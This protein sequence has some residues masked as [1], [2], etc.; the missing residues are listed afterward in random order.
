MKLFKSIRLEKHV[1]I[2]LATLLMSACVFVGMSY[3]SSSNDA[4]ASASSSSLS[5][6]ANSGND[7][8]VLVTGLP[9][10][11]Q[12]VEKTSPAVVNIRTTQKIAQ[13]QLD[14]FGED[15]PTQELLRRF[16]GAPNPMQPNPK[17]KRVQPKQQNRKCRAVWVPDLSSLPMALF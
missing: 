9:D 1:S 3:L 17:N 14:P 15:D 11:T 12:L 8:P 10:F 2:L 5:A 6:S 7:A 13:N 16:F 4:Q